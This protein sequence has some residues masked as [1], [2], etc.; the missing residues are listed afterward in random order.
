M[1]KFEKCIDALRVLAR[2]SDDP[3]AQLLVER[4]INEY[5]RSE[6]NDLQAA[7]SEGGVLAATMT[8]T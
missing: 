2:Q 1:D 8:V 3:S 7:A 6:V 5:L 4:R